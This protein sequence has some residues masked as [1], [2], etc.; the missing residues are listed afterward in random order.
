MSILRKQFLQHIGQT[1]PA[2]QLIEVARAEGVF[3]Y[4][5]EGKPY[6]DLISGVSVSNVGHGNPAVVDAVC[7]QARDYM[8]IMV[9]G[10]VVERPQVEYARKIAEAL[11]APLDSVY[12]LSSGA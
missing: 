3:F 6:Y 11:P 5:P 7:A 4:T 8:H 10:E 1:S 9:Y 2:P 12:F